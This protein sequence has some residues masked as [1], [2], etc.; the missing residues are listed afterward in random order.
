MLIRTGFITL[1]CMRTYYFRISACLSKWI[2]IQRIIDSVNII[3]TKDE[4]LLG[5]PRYKEDRKQA[6]TTILEFNKMISES[7]TFYRII[8]YAGLEN[9]DKK[10]HLLTAL[11]VGYNLSS[12]SLCLSLSNISS[13]NIANG[14]A[15]R[16]RDC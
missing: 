10:V 9:E 12:P 14:G 8:L 5:S 4:T 6:F 15:I 2:P 7:L 3:Q 16:P 1:D 11:Q 13:F